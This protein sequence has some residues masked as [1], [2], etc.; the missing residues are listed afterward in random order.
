MNFDKN[1]VYGRVFRL[2][3]CKDPSLTLAIEVI[4]GTHLNDIIVDNEI[5]STKLLKKKSFKYFVKL[6]P[7]SKMQ[8]GSP[9]EEVCFS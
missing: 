1:K 4:A 7:N 8:Y 3:Q 6:M 5:T 2:F 9:S